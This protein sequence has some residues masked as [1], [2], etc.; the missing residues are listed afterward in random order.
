MKKGNQKSFSR[1][2]IPLAES[3]AYLPAM[4]RTISRHLLE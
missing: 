1:F 3:A 4:T 2:P